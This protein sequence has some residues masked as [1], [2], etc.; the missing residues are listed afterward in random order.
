MNCA[1]GKPPSCLPPILEASYEWIGPNGFEAEG[2]ITIGPLTV[3]DAGLYVVSGMAGECEIVPDTL[4]LFVA[5]RP[6]HRRS[7]PSMR[8]VKG[9]TGRLLP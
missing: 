1:P 8:C 5:P 7:Y 4:E 3:D 2:E 9:M 6:P